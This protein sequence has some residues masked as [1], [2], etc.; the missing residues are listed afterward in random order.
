MFAVWSIPPV[1]GLSVAILTWK[2]YSA[3]DGKSVLTSLFTSP[4]MPWESS[5]DFHHSSYSEPRVQRECQISKFRKK[6]SIG[7]KSYSWSFIS[8]NYC[9]E[10]DASKNWNLTKI[11]NFEAEGPW[12]VMPP[13]VCFAC[14]LVVARFT[15]TGLLF[16]RLAVMSKSFVVALF[17]SGLS[18]TKEAP[19]TVLEV[20]EMGIGTNSVLENSEI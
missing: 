5:I 9:Y 3:N 20:K 19:V 12:L 11:D 15:R 18:N 17:F 16:L 7:F 6:D 2:Q 10:R 13:T 4:W 8:L 1:E 14:K